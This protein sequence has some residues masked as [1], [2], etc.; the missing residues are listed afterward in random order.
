MRWI[1]ALMFCA[2]T[3]VAVAQITGQ[4]G[5]GSLGVFNGGP[6]M[7]ITGAATGINGGGVT[8]TCN[9]TID[10]ST[11]CIQTILGGV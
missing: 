7:G 3:T 9:G 1:V 11:G 10:L 4:I 8:P 5:T 6:Q 2:A